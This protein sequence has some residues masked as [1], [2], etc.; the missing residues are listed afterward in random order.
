MTADG[1][2]TV[3]DVAVVEM[4]LDATV[5][6]V[7]AVVVIVGAASVF[8]VSSGGGSRGT[9]GGTPARRVTAGVKTVAEKKFSLCSFAK[10]FIHSWVH[11]PKSPFICQFV[12]LL[13]YLVFRFYIPLF[14]FWVICSSAH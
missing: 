8:V 1:A 5:E 4:R 2:A 3:A 6:I 7:V 12:R 13:N 11:M 9:L 14:I 10:D